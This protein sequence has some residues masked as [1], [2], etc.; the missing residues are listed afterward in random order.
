MAPIKVIMC[1]GITLM[2]LQ[3]IAT[4]FKDWAEAKGL[5][6]TDDGADDGGPEE[7]SPGA[8]AS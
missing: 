8:A 1:V 2:L 3:V 7:P 4:L 6:L 5:S